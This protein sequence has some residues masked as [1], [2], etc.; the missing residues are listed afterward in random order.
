MFRRQEIQDLIALTRVI[1]E[2]RDTLAVGALLRGPLV[3]LTDEELLD[4]VWALPR[5]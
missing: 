1:A 5:S 2:R 3:G 4:I